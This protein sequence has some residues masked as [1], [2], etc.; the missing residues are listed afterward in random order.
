M[1]FIV[2]KDIL[3]YF[4]FFNTELNEWINPKTIGLR[5]V[6]LGDEIILLFVVGVLDYVME[7]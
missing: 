7:R 5:L 4:K 6:E 3:E 1:W 2:K